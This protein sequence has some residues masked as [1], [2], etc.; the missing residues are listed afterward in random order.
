MRCWECGVWGVHSK[1]LI[2]GIGMGCGVWRIGYEYGAHNVVYGVRHTECGC[3]VG[4]WGMGYG[5]EMRVW[6]MRY[7]YGY[8]V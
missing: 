2:L 8:G 4:L 1:I 6:G 5:M 3:E 7:G